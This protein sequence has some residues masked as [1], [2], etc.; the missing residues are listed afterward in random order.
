LAELVA[1]VDQGVINNHAAKEVFELIAQTGNS[2]R[3]I[4]KEKGLEQVGSR[5]E[6]EAIIQQIVA[7][8]SA[9]VAEYKSGKEKM[10]GFFVGVAMKKTQGKGNPAIIQELLKKHLS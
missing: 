3:A 5:D 1:L 6:L 8:N 7:E 10:F 2:P 9:Q 4:V